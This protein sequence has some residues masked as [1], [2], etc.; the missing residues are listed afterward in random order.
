M[1]QSDR[2]D[3]YAGALDRLWAMG[4]LYPCTCT[5]RDI[6]EALAAPQEGAMPDRSRRPGL[7][8]H[9]P[10]APDARPPAPAPRRGPLRLDM[11]RAAQRRRHDLRCNASPKPARGPAGQ[12]GAIGISDDQLTQIGDIVL[13]RRDMGT[14]YHLSVVVDDAAQAITHVTRGADLFEAT[15]IHVILQRLIEPAHT[16]STTT[17]A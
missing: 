2:M 17:T 10:P 16:R 6:A 1:R 3:A 8:R 5:R 15:K 13:A 4:L 12:T 11:A 14:S 9:L 7:S